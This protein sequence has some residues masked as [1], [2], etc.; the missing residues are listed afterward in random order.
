M[1]FAAY[2]IIAITSK[3]GKTTRHSLSPKPLCLL[4]YFCF[5]RLVFVRKSEEVRNCF[6]LS[7][8]LNTPLDT[9]LSDCKV[10]QSLLTAEA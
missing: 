3:A 8:A 1:D 2:L 6:L 7:H 10:N 4:T 9:G 5:P